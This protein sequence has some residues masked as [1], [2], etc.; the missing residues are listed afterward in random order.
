MLGTLNVSIDRV[1]GRFLKESGMELFIKREDKIH[2]KISGNKWRK[3]KYNLIHAK[4]L[5][6]EQL[7]TFGGAFSNHIV[8]LAHAGKAYNFKTIGIIRGEKKINLNPS[9][10]YAVNSGMKLIYVNRENYNL[11]RENNS[12]LGNLLNIEGTYII[13][14]GGSNS[15]GVKGCE[16]IVIDLPDKYDFFCVPIGTGGTFCGMLKGLNGNSKLL[17]FPSLKGAFVQKMIETMRVEQKINFTN[18]EIIDAYHFGGYAKFNDQLI[19]FIN[20]FKK[21]S[22]IQ[23]DPIYTGKMLF[24]IYMLIKTG[25][26]KPKSKILAIHTGGLQGIDGFNQRFGNL[27]I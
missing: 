22:G 9:L 3:L 21:D 16:E 12:L 10:T 4:N 20:K 25:Y 26:F 27:L 1:N 19:S 15:L 5:G 11:I 18:F 13:P 7:L 8:A 6:Y 24:G 23:L 2:E 14:E 17:G